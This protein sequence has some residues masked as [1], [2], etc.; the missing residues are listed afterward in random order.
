M[1]E[2]FLVQEYESAACRGCKGVFM[3]LVVDTS[4]IIAVIANEPEKPALVAR[5]QGTELFAPRSLHWEIGNAFSAMLKRQRIRLEQAQAAVKI[6]EQISLNLV[7]VDLAQA[8][9]IA[10]RLNIYAYDAYIIACALNQN[11]F[12]LTLDGGLSYAAKAA[13]VNVVEVNGPD[14]DIS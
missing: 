1:K 6:Y 4:V 3:N 2:V 8:L 10:S 14:A 12:L 13:G 9:E 5:T 7:D 11:C